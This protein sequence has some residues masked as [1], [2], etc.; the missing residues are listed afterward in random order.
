MLLNHELAQEIVDKTMKI[1]KINVNIFDDKGYI[2][3]SGQKERLNTFHEG[4]Y[5]VIG[6]GLSDEF[7]VEK[8]KKYKGVQPGILYPIEFNNKIIGVVG[9]TGDPEEIRNYG[10]LVKMTTEM[11]F[12]QDFLTKQL[13][14]EKNARDNY[15]KDII[16]GQFGSD[17]DSFIERGRNFEIDVLLERQAVVID[18]VSGQNN[19]SLLSSELERQIHSDEILRI[20]E[21]QFSHKENLIVYMGSGRYVVLKRVDDKQR[22]KAAF[23]KSMNELSNKLGEHN[24]NAVIGIGST[25]IHWLNLKA[26]FVEACDAIK[27][28]MKVNDEAKVFHIQDLLLEKGLDTMD[29]NIKS[30]LITSFLANAE[31]VEA[32]QRQEMEKTLIALF[33]SNLNVSEAAKKLFLHRNSLTYRL[34]K[35][36]ESTGLDPLSFYDVVKIYTALILSRLK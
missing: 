17:L 6:T 34:K 24:F 16:L 31:H 3:G 36:S 20:L 29:D 32:K 2:I 11:M 14:A 9:M 5:E 28:G 19:R 26:S 25:Q 33:D 12:R 4:A 7:P 8:A 13:R 22:S 10:A 35:L 21:Y 30:S 27:I 15:I 23:I 18:L 1:I